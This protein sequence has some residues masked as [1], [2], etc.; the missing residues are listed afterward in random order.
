[1]KRGGKI[2]IWLAGGLVLSAG[3]SADS[4]APENTVARANIV[5]PADNPYAAIV[6]RNIFG[7]NPIVASDE[8]VGDPPPKITLN[9][10][11]STFGKSQAL[12]KVAGSAKPGEP[13]KDQSY[14][15]SEGQ[16]QDDI[17][18]MRINDK[19]NLVTFNNHGTVQEIPLAN[20]PKSALSAPAGPSG[21][22]SGRPGLPGP[23]GGRNDGNGGNEPG[24]FPGRGGS[25]S[26][27]N[28]SLGNG[29]NQNQNPNQPAA[30]GGLTLN[31]LQS[32]PTRSSIYN[33]PQDQNPLT[34]EQN[35]TLIEIQRQLYQNDPNPLNQRM[36]NLLPPTKP[37]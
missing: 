9:G 34:S 32:A 1:M 5:A 20:A 24:I 33:P 36:A 27:P 14:I 30:S 13:A 21:P 6:T 37:R 28:R 19:D 7:L 35:D 16:R 25:N 18:V 17:E 10:I 29:A 31:S 15:L 3:A 2:A 11:M 22:V 4:V 26:R 23:R 12:Y 8:P